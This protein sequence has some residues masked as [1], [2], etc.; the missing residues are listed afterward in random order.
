[1][2]LSQQRAGRVAR[3]ERQCMGGLAGP[4]RGRMPER[5][6][7]GNRS[8]ES[9]NRL[10]TANRGWRERDPIG[11]WVRGPGPM[12]SSG[13]RRRSSMNDSYAKAK[14]PTVTAIALARPVQ[15]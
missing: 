13:N 9:R 5:C 11:P 10:G 15:K 3:D 12:G 14:A 2:I 4:Q 1:V 7:A 8:I 6:G